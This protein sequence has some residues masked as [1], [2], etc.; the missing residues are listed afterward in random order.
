MIWRCE[1]GGMGMFAGFE[2]RGIVCRRR[3]VRAGFCA[4][5]LLVQA[6]QAYAV[7]QFEARQGDPELV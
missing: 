6:V 2:V 4:K 7:F 5:L 1:A 3:A